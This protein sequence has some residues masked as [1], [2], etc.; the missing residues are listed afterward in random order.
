MF[1]SQVQTEGQKHC[2]LLPTFQCF[3][4]PIEA[5][6]FSLEGHRKIVTD[7]KFSQDSLSLF[8][9][10][11]DGTVVA[12]DTKT[13]EA[14]HK[15]S[16]LNAKPG[17]HTQLLYADG[18][19]VLETYTV[20]S[21]LY[22]IEEKTGNVKSQFSEPRTG[23]VHNTQL[24]GHKALREGVFYDVTNGARLTQLD[25]LVGLS[26]FV[27]S[28]MTPN[29]RYVLVGE[30]QATTLLDVTTGEVCLSLPGEHPACATAITKNS[31]K[32]VV[33][34]SSSCLVKVL[35]IDPGSEEFGAVLL[36]FDHQAAYPSR[37]AKADLQY[38][39]EVSQLVLSHD[40][41]FVVMNI[42]H[43][44]L[45][46]LGMECGKSASME[47]GCF[48]GNCRIH[49]CGFAIDNITVI[50]I[51][52]RHLCLWNAYR[53]TILAQMPLSSDCEDEFH[54]AVA[55][56]HG[57][58]A[59]VN[60]REPVI[61]LW[62]IG[63]L[64][65]PQ[66]PNVHTY[67][68]PLS[69][70]VVATQQKLAFIKIFH[71]LTSKKGHHYRD[72]FGLDVWNLATNHHQNYLPF[73]NYGSLVHIEVSVDGRF[74]VLLTEVSLVGHVFVIDIKSGDIVMKG[75]HKLCYGA[76]L[77]PSGQ[78]LL[79]ESSMG[80]EGA[81]VMVWETSGAHIK[82]F[83]KAQA[84]IFSSD[85]ACVVCLKGK[86][87]TKYCLETKTKV[88]NKFTL[89]QAERLQAIPNR[90]DVMVV[91]G[92]AFTG[93]SKGHKEA[94]VW[95]L[96]TGVVRCR[97]EGIAPSGLIDLAK[98]GE[99]GVDGWLQVYDLGTGT[100]LL[101]C[102]DK[103]A[104]VEP[105][106]EKSTIRMTYDGRY[107][108]WA[109]TQP[110][111]CIK[112]F[113]VDGQ[114]LVAEVSTHAKVLSLSLTDFGYSVIT[115]CEDGRILNFSLHTSNGILDEDDDDDVVN[116]EDDL[117][118]DL[119]DQEEDEEDGVF[120]NNI[121]TL[122]KRSSRS[123]CSLDRIDRIS[124]SGEKL[125]QKVIEHFDVMYQKAPEKTADSDL[126]VASE[127]VKDELEANARFAREVRVNAVCGQEPRRR[128]S[129][130]C[131]VL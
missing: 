27:V 122:D 112:V 95:D 99:I 64:Q 82:A 42:N 68:N 116:I 130:M 78:H 74:L 7:M 58:L 41:R 126:P 129:P 66:A 84:A 13:G 36:S 109:D 76:Q 75:S 30:A 96:L 48:E 67:N 103:G 91:T 55:S 77:S 45:F 81:E 127:S 98:N 111:H 93:G 71:P 63:K 28:E 108:L 16:V 59:T 29:Q 9:V 85:S 128:H 22:V 15:I 20:G 6:A 110:T 40:N 10:S 90:P 88:S 105:D 24:R 50:A 44:S 49:E 46:V 3:D 106:L 32:A 123:N 14:A 118:L 97:L 114:K 131:C 120:N 86:T 39:Q 18:F 62:D 34:F 37:R 117:D 52:G 56:S 69:V 43:N 33:G 51:V 94:V 57:L 83:D 26:D 115:G 100:C 38:C 87:L 107:V 8:S 125:P 101:R 119:D 72:F 70:V 53:G 61:K 65:E 23:Y 54:M 12:W 35:N 124:T 102:A 121:V 60:K 2:S 31:T 47:L 21:P 113:Q 4:A 25:Y 5:L 19:M 11:L 17:R 104:A 89:F 92:S 79:M 73:G 80:K 1:L